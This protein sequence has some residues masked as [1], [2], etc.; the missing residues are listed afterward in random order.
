MS[1]HLTISKT[2]VVE[3]LD[4]VVCRFVRQFLE[5]PICS[6]FSSLILNTS[7]HGINLILPSVK[8]IEFQ[9]IIRNAMK[10]SRDPDIKSLWADLSYGIDL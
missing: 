1:W 8:F 6:N 9:I 4:S 3:N 5:V 10:S 2:W 7:R